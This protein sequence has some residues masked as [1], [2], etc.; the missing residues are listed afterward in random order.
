MT[1]DARWVQ[2]SSAIRTQ[3]SRFYDGGDPGIPPS[4]PIPPDSSADVIVKLERR[5]V[6]IDGVEAETFVLERRIAYL[7]RHCG[8]IIVPPSYATFE[9]DLTSVPRMF[10]WLVPKTGK[11]LPAALI[12]DGLVGDPGAP[13]YTS[14]DGH[15]IGRVEADRI[16]R[17][18]M[19][20]VG[21]SLVRRWL[22]WTAV[23][24]ATMVA[25]RDTSTVGWRRHYYR[26]VAVA[27]LLTIG[28]LGYLATADLFD[29]SDRWWFTYGLRWMGEG[30]FWHE[31]ISGAAGAVVIPL[32]LG[33]LWGKFRRAGWIG[34]LS[35]GMLFHVS[36]VLIVVTVAFT[37]LEWIG[38]R[39]RHAVLA[40]LVGAV[41]GLAGFA[42][43]IALY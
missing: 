11:H 22:V 26:W 37:A 35:V 9:T 34:G 14:T 6:S 24:V 16:F 32:A 10:T 38:D 36:A 2:L 12:H 33:L 39:V 27:T 23:T 17:D 15:S 31:L 28:W 3:R 5:I 13:T 7:D 18:G 21:T 43:V 40:A 4:P 30:S 19:A 1:W 42:F 41:F 29:R 20:D 8:E 25:A